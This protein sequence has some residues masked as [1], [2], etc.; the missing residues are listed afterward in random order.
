MGAAPAR[1]ARTGI[2]LVRRAKK[3]NGNEQA[4]DGFSRPKAKDEFGGE[5]PF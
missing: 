1:T 4:K 5:I 2:P 3:A